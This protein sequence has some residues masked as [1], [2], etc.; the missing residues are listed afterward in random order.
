MNTHFDQNFRACGS[1]VDNDSNVVLCLLDTHFDKTFLG[2]AKPGDERWSSVQ[3]DCSFYSALVFFG[4][5]YCATESNLMVLQTSADQPPRME[6]A[7]KLPLQTQFSPIQDTM[8]L[9][10]SR[11]KLMLVHCVLIRTD[12]ICFEYFVYQLDLDTGKRILAKSFSGRALF[13]GMYCSLSVS[14]E[15][16]P[17]IA[18]DTMYLSRLM[19]ERAVLQIEAH[20]LAHEYTEDLTCNLDSS[21]SSSPHTLVECLAL[22]HTPNIRHQTRLI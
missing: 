9:V 5:F 14:P 13:I 18:R 17:S 7:T 16:F 21:M 20:N 10:E 12:P 11:G 22:C 2:T 6:V 15:V 19:D 1:G 8:H 3:Y 4:H